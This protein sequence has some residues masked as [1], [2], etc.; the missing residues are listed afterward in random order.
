MNN[1]GEVFAINCGLSATF[2]RE[3]T[4][5]RGNHAELAAGH[6]EFRFDGPVPRIVTFSEIAAEKMERECFAL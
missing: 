3:W 4:A 2:D 5:Q 1:Q 6:Y